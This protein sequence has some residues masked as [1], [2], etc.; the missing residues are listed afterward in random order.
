MTDDYDT[1]RKIKFLEII[2]LLYNEN[3]EFKYLMYKYGYERIRIL[4]YIENKNLLI[5]LIELGFIYDSENLVYYYNE[6]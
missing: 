6:K 1:K 5:K 3:V 2:T 4:S